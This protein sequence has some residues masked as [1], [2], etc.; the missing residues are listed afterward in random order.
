MTT[1][2]TIA[3]LTAEPAGEDVERVVVPREPTP[4]MTARWAM[5]STRDPESV[6]AR[7]LADLVWRTMLAAAPKHPTDDLQR[8]REAEAI[9]LIRTIHAEA[10]CCAPLMSV[11]RGLTERFLSTVSKEPSA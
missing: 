10:T 7:V 4:E 2:D 3:R 11:V 6:E 5:V 1:P 9:E 8:T